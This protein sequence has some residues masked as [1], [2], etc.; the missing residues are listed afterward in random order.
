MPES[1]GAMTRKPCRGI[2]AGA[3]WTDGRRDELGGRVRRVSCTGLPRPERSAVPVP[4]GVSTWLAFGLLLVFITLTLLV[5]RGVTQSVDAAVLERLRPGG[6]WG[7]TQ[8]RY[9]PWMSRLRPLHMYLLLGATSIAVALWRRSWWPVAFSLV[10]VG[11]SGAVTL[12]VKGALHRPDSGGWVTETGG[13][14]P[15]GHMVALV[16]C[17]GAC[18]L[19]VWPRVRWWL[20]APA[21]VPT[22]LLASALLVSGAH[23]LTDVLGGLLLALAAITASSRSG[24][25]DRAH[26]RAGTPAGVGQPLRRRSP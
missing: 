4:R 9:T 17:L 18:L 19:V 21:L 15:S 26:R 25:R 11:A 14:Y 7:E 20:W 8:L 22:S 2:R 13:A 5:L 10:L 6:V 24:L 16:T 1:V 12:V 23:W 3:A